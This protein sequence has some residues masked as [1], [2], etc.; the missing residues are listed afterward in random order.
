MRRQRGLTLVELLVALGVFG[1]VSAASVGVLTL[2]V[3]GQSQL[4]LRTDEVMRLERARALL[5]ADLLQLAP[6]PVREGPSGREAEVPAFAGGAELTLPE[7]APDAEVLFVLT[8][9]G[10]QNPDSARPRAELQR[11]TYLLKDDALIRRTRPFL[12]AAADTPT[13]DQV[14]LEDVE[15]AEVAFLSEG[16]WRDGFAGQDDGA[17]GPD[18]LRIEMTLPGFGRLRQ[19][20]LARVP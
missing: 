6:R 1:F 10:W 3:N 9:G 8:R 13:L 7:T 14:L 2:A 5:R 16:Q 4:E 18:A 11:V 17:P 12:D 19:D 20:F 15:D